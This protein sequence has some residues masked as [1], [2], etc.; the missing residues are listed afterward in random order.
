[1]NFITDFADQ[2]VILPLLVAV[3]VL[4]LLQ[5][6]YRGALAWAF[7]TVGTLAVM[8]L[9]KLVFI[10]CAPVFWTFN[11]HTPS[12]HAAAAA[13]GAGGMATLLLRRRWLALPL[14]LLATIVIAAS[15]LALGMH[16]VPEVLMGGAVGLAGAV[17]LFGLAGPVPANLN[18]RRIATVA[19]IVIIVFHGFRLPAEA[20]IQATAKRMAL[21]L[22]V[23]Q[24]EE[25]RP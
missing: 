25:S 8:L 18:T 21:A 14:A 23:C 15:R 3:F 9:L 13:L 22:G 7:A 10:S 6:W 19:L 20:H 2:A 16:S 1:M 17:V 4:L 5:G 11:L 24:A 12:G